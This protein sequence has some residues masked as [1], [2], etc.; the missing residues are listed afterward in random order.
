M[1]CIVGLL[2]KKED[3]VYVGADSL[4]SNGYY[5]QLFRN[6]KVF[7][8]IDNKNIVMAI[9]GNWLLE[10]FLSSE[11][12]LIEEIKELKNEV[13]LEHIVRYTVPKIIQLGK[14]FNFYDDKNHSLDGDIIF[15]YKNKIFIIHSNGQVLIPMDDYIVSGCGIEFALGSLSESENK[16]TKDRI[17]EA[18]TAAEKHGVGIQRPFYILNTKNDEVVE[19]K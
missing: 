16:P 2:D 19:I 5:K 17:T 1:T 7:K 6:R 15:S 3:C 9:S 12:N 18:L 8:A 11:K 13:N 14:T 4:G 10:N